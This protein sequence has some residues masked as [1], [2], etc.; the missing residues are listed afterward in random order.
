[1]GDH[2][3]HVHV[4]YSISGAPSP[5]GALADGLATDERLLDSAQWRRLIQRLGEIENP[6]VKPTKKRRASVA[7]NGE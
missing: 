2:A 3:D 6:K 1:M 4:G 5:G 7:H